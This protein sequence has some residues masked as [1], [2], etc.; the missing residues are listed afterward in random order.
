MNKKRIAKRNFQ[1]LH[2][3]NT[4]Y[5]TQFNDF[6]LIRHFRFEIQLILERK[7]LCTTNKSLTSIDLIP[8]GTIDSSYYKACLR[9]VGGSTQVPFCFWNKCTELHLM[10]QS[11]KLDRRKMSYTVLVRLKSQLMTQTRDILAI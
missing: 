4:I 3:N 8:R 1:K 10:S 5:T 7:K 6:C 9:N 11:V 2:I